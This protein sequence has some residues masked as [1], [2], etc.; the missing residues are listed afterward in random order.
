MQIA[1]SQ[2]ISLLT[3]PYSGIAFT[4]LNVAVADLG[5][6]QGFHGKTL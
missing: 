5:G 6:F 1:N 2:A 4:E 3:G